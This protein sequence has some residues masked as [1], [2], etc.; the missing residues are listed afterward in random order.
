MNS[1]DSFS[2]RDEQIINSATVR[3]LIFHHTNTSYPANAKLKSVEEIIRALAKRDCAD[4]T[5]LIDPN[6]CGTNPYAFGGFC[7][8]YQGALYDGTKIAIKSLRVC[9]GPGADDQRRKILKVRLTM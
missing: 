1:Q 5:S 3:V 6:A 8:V 4:L 2:K 7:D 9:D